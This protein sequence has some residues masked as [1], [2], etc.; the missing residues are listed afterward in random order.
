[1]YENFKNVEEGAVL[2]ILT[3]G[4]HE[5]SI[6]SLTVSNISTS[7]FT[8]EVADVVIIDKDGK[9]VKE[10]IFPFAVSP[11]FKD[12]TTGVVKTDKEQQDIYLGKHK[13]LFS[14]ACVSEEAMIA[15][16]SLATSFP[17]Y[18]A[19]LAKH[20]VKANGGKEFRVLIV[21][22]KG[23][24]TYPMWKGGS[25]E[26]LT[27]SS[28]AFDSVKHGPKLKPMGIEPSAPGAEDDMPF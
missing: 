27:D 21:D 16:V 8:G 15:D 6:E 18:I 9:N 25:A 17:T 20:V 11:N 22:K 10:R 14:K 19:A 2:S 1:M 28:L 13:H 4:L 7:G 24:S 3:P 26:A 12:F 23:F 5:V